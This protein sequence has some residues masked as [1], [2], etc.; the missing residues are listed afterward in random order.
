MSTRRCEQCENCFRHVESIYCSKAVKNCNGLHSPQLLTCARCK[1]V[2]YCSRTCQ[3]LQWKE[4]KSACDTQVMIMW[5]LKVLSPRIERTFK[6]FAKF[7][8]NISGY[9]ETPA[10]SALELYKGK[11]RVETHVFFIKIRAKETIFWQNKKGTK[12]CITFKV[13][14]AEGVTMKEMHDFLDYRSGPLSTPEV[15]DRTLAHRPGLL[16]IFVHDVSGIIPAPIDGYTLPTDIANW[17]SNYHKRYDPDWLEHFLESIG[18]RLD[19]PTKSGLDGSEFEL[20]PEGEEQPPFTIPP[21]RPSSPTEFDDRPP[22]PE[23]ALKELELPSR[24][25]SPC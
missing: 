19:R 2:R 14:S 10:I 4:H 17:P 22:N 15:T 7:C 9:L 5:T 8:K 23:A 3:R 11:H 21:A 1:E 13:E 25:T 20:E 6:A 12:G 18:Q 24:P 16:R